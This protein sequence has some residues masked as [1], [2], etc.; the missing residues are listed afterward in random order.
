MFKL[1]SKNETLKFFYNYIGKRVYVIILISILIGVLDGLGLTM[2]LPLLDYAASDGSS[3]KQ[4]SNFIISI[5]QNTGID[6]SLSII[7]IFMGGFFILKGLIQYLGGLYNVSVLTSFIKNLRVKNLRGLNNLKYNFFLKSDVGRIQNTLTGE[8]DRVATSTDKYFRTIQY[9]ILVLV[10]MLFAFAV[11]MQFAIMVT[12]GG[13]LTNFVYRALYR[14]TKGESDKLT[15]ENHIFQKLIIQQVANFKYLKAT[16][17][18]KYYSK[19]LETSIERIKRNTY[20]IGKLDSFLTAA[21]EP[22]LV[23]V[24]IIVIYLQ[25]NFFGSALG[26]I[27]ISLLFFYRALNYLMQMQ[28]NWNKFLAYSGSL[29]NI[30]NFENE[31]KDNFESTGEYELE[32]K[33]RII[34]LD[35]L[36]FSYSKDVLIL[37]NINLNIEKNQSVAFVGRSGS[38]K[39]T[40]VNLISGL[41]KPSH[42]EIKINDYILS[43]INK[44][45]YQNRIGYITQDPVIFNDTIL[46]NI[47][48]SVED[49]NEERFWSV[50]EKAQLVDFIKDL[51]NKENEILGTNG[52]NLS[53]GQKQRISIARELYKNVELLILDEATSALDSETEMAIQD[54]INNLQ[55]KYTILSIAHRLSTIKNADK[56]VVMDKGEIVAT[57]KFNDL[58]NESL[59]FK[60]LVELQEM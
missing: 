45:S 1:L 35:D 30:K 48:F 22:M 29:K 53:G 44:D 40:L 4:S 58:Y 31:L 24:V 39:T 12:I 28:I 33:L 26:P 57:G 54:S 46:N 14:K 34:K 38:G 25:I 5:F 60:K 32:E 36:Y 9:S 59:Y 41:L 11:D 37:K 16:G 23:L 8:I 50:I 21:R 2:F 52:V 55:G 17:S 51:P 47:V 15:G 43:E 27:L 18:I 7:L 20:R 49:F 56:I 10:Y 6:F 19:K 42:G 13:G 3:P